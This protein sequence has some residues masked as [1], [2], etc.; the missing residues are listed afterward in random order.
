MK[1]HT[2]WVHFFQSCGI[3]RCVLND[4]MHMHWAPVAC[5]LASQNSLGIKGPIRAWNNALITGAL[6]RLMCYLTIP[7][8]WLRLRTTHRGI[9]RKDN[10]N[11]NNNDSDNNWL[12]R[13]PCESGWNHISQ[14]PGAGGGWGS[15]QTA[16]CPDSSSTAGTHRS[17]C[18]PS[19]LPL[20]SLSS[21]MDHEGVM[22][23]CAL[24]GSSSTQSS[25][26]WVR[27][28]THTCGASLILSEWQRSGDDLGD[29]LRK[30][31]EE[32]RIPYSQNRVQRAQQQQQQKSRCG[33]LRL[34]R[35]YKNTT[36]M[37][38]FLP[39]LQNVPS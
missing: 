18:K 8:V 14:Q 25:G 35:R 20:T 23:L 7:A 12:D 5:W 38:S 1:P 24:E 39:L 19:D 34:Q 11:N 4:N 21:A 13:F 37:G 22:Q 3:T 2:S 31:G 29:F 36:E 6:S 27:L 15:I 33:R 32:S 26:I 9:L 17:T 10:N 16:G 30:V 28:H